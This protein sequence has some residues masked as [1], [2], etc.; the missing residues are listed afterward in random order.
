LRGAEPGEGEIA[1][2]HE[3]GAAMTG[4]LGRTTVGRPSCFATVSSRADRFTA[5]PMQVKSSQLPAPM[6]P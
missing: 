5:G 2:R 4:E 3:F 6:L 1:E